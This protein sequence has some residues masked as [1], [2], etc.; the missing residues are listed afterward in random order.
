[1]SKKVYTIG[2]KY[3]KLFVLKEVG[4]DKHNHIL[5]LCRCDCGKKKILV[6]SDVRCGAV[7]S[8]GCLM[9]SEERAK[10]STIHGQTNTRFYQTWI[11]MRQRCN[12]PKVKDF[13]N[14]GGRGIKCL[15]KSFEEFYKDMHKEYISHIKKYGKNQTS[16]DRINNDGHY[17]KKNCRWAT[18]KIQRRNSR[19]LNL[20]THKG[21]TK[22]LSAWA[23]EL[24]IERCTIKERIKKGWSIEDA[25]YK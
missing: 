19:R 22:C 18:Y 23:E 16:I 11:T 4:H 3:N 17:C 7:R 12:N 24:D 21:Q 13:K 25:F 10:R 2:K 1:M 14:Y 20:I 5:Y 15:W 6:G 8:C 9:L